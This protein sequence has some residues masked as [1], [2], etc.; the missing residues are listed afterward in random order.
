MVYAKVKELCQEGRRGKKQDSV[1]SKDGVL[2]TEA[3]DISNRWKG[4][5]EELYA[6]DEKPDSLPLE[7]EEEVDGDSRGPD[8]LGGNPEGNTPAEGRQGRRR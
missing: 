1:L 3:C 2:L 7:V 5:I 4:Y 8:I 6:S